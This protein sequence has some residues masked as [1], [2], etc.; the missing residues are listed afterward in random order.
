M[1]LI[2]LVGYVVPPPNP[3]VHVTDELE[4]SKSGS[5]LL[6]QI[7][8]LDQDSISKVIQ[9]MDDLWKHES[10]CEVLQSEADQKNIELLSDDHVRTCIYVTFQSIFSSA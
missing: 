10:T 1:A 2:I 8:A 5:E 6:L 3:D 4:G 7:H 9:D